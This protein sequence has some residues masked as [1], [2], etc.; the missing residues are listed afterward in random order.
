MTAKEKLRRR[1][2]TLTEEQAAEALRV[3]DLRVEDPV[4]AAFDSA[5]EDDEPW[6]QEDEAAAEESRAEYRRGEGVRLDEIRH[7]FS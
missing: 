1:V 4:L 3:L 6:T 5:P 2:E 7:E